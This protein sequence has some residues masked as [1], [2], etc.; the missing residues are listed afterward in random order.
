MKLWKQVLSGIVCL[1]MLA[2]GTALSAFADDSSDEWGTGGY[3]G[4]LNRDNILSVAD[5]II[6]QKYLHGQGVLGSEV[7]A[8]H[9]DINEDEKINIIDLAMLKQRV[10]NQDYWYWGIDPAESQGGT[11]PDLE[12]FISAP[13]YPQYNSM[14]SQGTVNVVFFYVDFPDCPYE[15]EPSLDD[16]S[17]YIFGSSESDDP[18]DTM[19]S[20]Y[21]RSSKGA[22]NLQGRVFRYTTKE[23][24]SAYENYATWDS[25]YKDKEKLI[26]ECMNAF[27]DS[28]DFSQFDAD[29]DNL[30]DAVVISVPESAGDDYWWC[31][32]GPSN[33]YAVDGVRV[34]DVVTGNAEVKEQSHSNFV[35]SYLHEVGHCM[36]LPDYYLYHSSD[37]DEGFH[38][39]AGTELMD[40]DAH[41]D[42]GC[43]SKLMFGWY[44]TNQVQVFD[45]NQGEQQTF[46]LNNAQTSEGNCLILPYGEWNGNYFSEYM[47]MEYITPD[48]N[49]SDIN[50]NPNFNFFCEVGNGIRIYHVRADMSPSTGTARSFVYD[51]IGTYHNSTQSDDGIRVLRLAND[52]EGGNVFQTGDVVNGNISG[53]HWYDTAGNES[54]ETGYEITVGDLVDGQYTVT[55]TKK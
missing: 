31:E 55:V 19:H 32:A 52:A 7:I 13:I 54:I 5:I 4:D 16:L 18:F 20:F 21:E 24:K 2:T 40:T 44:K 3:I 33:G 41:S 37:D 47:I 12:E 26:Q 28:L 15:Y 34:G 46:V 42:F 30:I 27:K 53:F 38:G 9:A 23:N 51:G 22:L 6:L 49:N 45:P 50:Q 35:G 11:Q 48:G 29:G 8:Y 10:I 39:S 1:T 36:G 43:F 14:P 17:Y 25:T